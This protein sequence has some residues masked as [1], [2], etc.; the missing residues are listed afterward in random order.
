MR[1]N[2]YVPR[3]HYVWGN[4]SV[5]QSGK[6][7]CGCVSRGCIAW[8]SLLTR[9]LS[10]H[11]LEDKSVVNGSVVRETGYLPEANHAYYAP[12]RPPKQYTVDQNNI[13]FRHLIIHFP[14]SSGVSERA[15]ER[16]S[17]VKCTSEANE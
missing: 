15:S 8:G 12:L 11:A 6:R 13:I 7:G 3:I 10:S 5:R 4:A 1:V 9:E 17:A 14:T 16:M 2:A